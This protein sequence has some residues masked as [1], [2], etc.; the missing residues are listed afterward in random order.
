[1]RRRLPESVEVWEGAV[2]VE[3]GVAGLSAPQ[4][5]GVS[6]S[7]LVPEG[8]VEV[9]T[10]TLPEILAGRRPALVKIDIEGYEIELLPSLAPF[11]AGLG[12]PM[13]V[14]LHGAMPDPG[15]FT[16]YGSVAMPESPHGALVARP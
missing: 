11:L 14:A 3:P 15:W 1:L 12:V 9:R 13:Q 6:G 10:W 7:R 5:L 2:A 16:G 8:N 4:R